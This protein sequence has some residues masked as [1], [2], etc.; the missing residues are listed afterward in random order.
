MKSIAP[1]LLA[2]LLLTSAGW[3]TDFSKAQADAVQSNKH[4]LLKFSGSDWCIPCIRM[5]KTIFEAEVFEAYADE[6]LVLVNA[7]FPQQKKNMPATEIVKQN[8]ML[9]E[10]Y[11][12]E[13]KFPYTILLDA[14]GKVIKSWA[15]YKDGTAEEFVNQLKAAIDEQ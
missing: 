3:R 13:G 14:E 1:L 11:N 12:K 4:V 15:G 5:E 7:D 2:L 8:E 6:H 9:A 10:Q